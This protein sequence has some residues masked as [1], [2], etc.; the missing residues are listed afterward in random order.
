MTSETRKVLKLSGNMVTIDI[1][2]ETGEC[3]AEDAASDML[4]ALRWA[5]RSPHH[6]ACKYD[7]QKCTCH[8][9]AA[10]AAIEKAGG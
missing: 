10:R 3:I 5:A 4:E 1:D 2:R 8:V 9:G 6:P 7:G